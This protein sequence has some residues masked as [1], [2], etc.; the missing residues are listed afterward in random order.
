MQISLGAPLLIK[1]VKGEFNPLKLAKKEIKQIKVPMTVKRTM[2]SGEQSI[3]DIK[4]GIKNWIDE[5][6]GEII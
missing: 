6:N 3:I 4:I 1:E 5:H 2:P